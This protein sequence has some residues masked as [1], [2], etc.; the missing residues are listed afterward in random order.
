MTMTASDPARLMARLQDLDPPITVLDRS[1]HRLHVQWQ[2]VKVSY[3]WQ[4]GVRLEGDKVV[5]GIPLASLSTLATLKCHAIGNRG[6]RK[7][8]IDLYALLQDGWSL[9]QVL[10]V[11][12]DQAPA[13][14]HAH[15]LRSLTYFADAEHD[16]SPRLY[17]S[18]AWDDIKHTLTQAVHQHLQQ[19]LPRGP[20]L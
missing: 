15:V 19:Q 20:K 16:P 5:D 7:D 13:L 11:A 4:P 18:W 14:N 1:D 8:F 2:G 9:G 6:S 3:L 10:K 17:R 12:G